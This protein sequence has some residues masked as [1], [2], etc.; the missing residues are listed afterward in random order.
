M[1]LVRF[2]MQ[3]IEN[4]EISGTEYQQGTLAGY[5]VREY[6]LLKWGHACAYCSKQNVPLQVE[7]ILP[8]A[9]GGSNRVNNLCIACEPCNQKKGTQDIAQFLGKKPELLKTI[10]AQAKAPLGDAAAVN[11]TRWALF[12]RLQAFGL[13]V[14][15]GSGGQTKFNRTS[16]GLPKTHWVDAAN[17]GKTT[18]ETVQIK[19]VIPLLIGAKGHG[20]RRMG[21]P[22]KHGFIIR[23]R[24]RQKKHFGY[25]TGDLVRAVVPSGKYQGVHVGRVL[26]R[27]TG[28]FDIT[29]RAGRV[30]GI[31]HNSCHPTHQSDGYSYTRGEAYEPGTNPTAQS[32]S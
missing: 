23:H 15:C 5:E 26:A 19:G 10:Q 30:Q 21:Y 32:A 9:R 11:A 14:E 25:Q 1:E 7:H 3:A 4:P 2:D 8:K 17:V 18:P 16:R 27:A 24:K 13:P 31:S 22:D 6:L 12:E 29:T 20:N 28:S